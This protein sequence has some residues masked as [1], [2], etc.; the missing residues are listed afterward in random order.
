M[1]HTFRIFQKID[2]F[3][4][5]H[6]GSR[7][8]HIDLH[9]GNLAYEMDNKLTPEQMESLAHLLILNADKKRQTIAKLKSL[10]SKTAP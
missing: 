2:G 4:Y 3:I 5:E 8:T 9:V 7:F 10:T 6:E 1:N